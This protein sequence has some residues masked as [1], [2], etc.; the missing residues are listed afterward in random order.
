[1]NANR[2]IATLCCFSRHPDLAIALAYARE[3][4]ADVRPELLL[5]NFGR[6]DEHR[7]VAFEYVVLRL[8]FHARRN[9]IDASTDALV[10]ATRDALELVRRPRTS[11]KSREQPIPSAAQRAREF[12]VRKATY[13]ALRGAAARYLEAGIA[14]GLQRFLQVCGSR[15]PRAP[16]SRQSDHVGYSVAHRR[17]SDSIR[18]QPQQLPRTPMNVNDRGAELHP[19][20]SKIPPAAADSRVA[21]ATKRFTRIVNELEHQQARADAA[22][23]RLVDKAKPLSSKRDPME[24]AEIILAGRTVTD[25]RVDAEKEMYEARKN[26]DALKRALHQAQHELSVARSYAGA[27]LL[28][29]I[30]PDIEAQ[31]HRIRDAVLIILDATAELN[32]I[33]GEILKKGYSL[34]PQIRW[35]AVDGMAEHEATDAARVWLRQNWPGFLPARTGPESRDEMWARIESEHQAATWRAIAARLPLPRWLGGGASAH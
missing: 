35:F 26:V 32:A 4:P 31:E 5:W 13:L 27:E 29:Q 22:Y 3:H 8:V 10:A 24:E 1:V 16:A 20:E 28:P 23:V 11:A 7:Q 30:K 34:T 15:E 33:T 2:V 25:A 17:M 19:F 6:C 12:G 9:A 21:A 14:A 18:Q